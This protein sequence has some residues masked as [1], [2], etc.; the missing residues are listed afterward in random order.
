M[1][2]RVRASFLPGPGAKVRGQARRPAAAHDQ[3]LARA[4]CWRP[5]ASMS[6]RC[7]RAS[8]CPH[9]LAAATNPKSSTGRLDV[10]TRVIAD[11]VSAFDQIPA[12]YNGP[13]FAE[14]CPQ[15]F[16]DR[17]AQGLAAVPDP[18]PR[19]R[20][21]DDGGL[22][23]ARPSDGIPTRRVRCSSVD[24]AGDA[25]ASSAIAP[26]ATPAWSMST[27]SAACRV[28]RLL[29]ADHVREQN[30]AHPRPGPVL[31]PGLQGGR[32]RAADPCRRDGAVQ[33]AGRRVPRALCRA[34]SIRASAMPR[35]AA[36]GAKAV[37]EVRS[38]KVP[39]ILEDGQIIGPPDLRA[40]DGDAGARST[41][42]TSAPTTRR[43][44]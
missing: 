3:P 13:L 23:A 10:F 5:A 6:C 15:T 40:A 16:P 17:R 34:S 27:R 1:A 39:F 29:G 11:G 20:A 2:Y 36:T 22:R 38:H 43:R 31:H 21:R 30:A 12:G 4:R 41:A 7:S 35:R 44:A 9:D 42:A 18:L 24:L 28:A 32:A 26:S 14:I 19:R 25:T 33:S 8:R 37:L